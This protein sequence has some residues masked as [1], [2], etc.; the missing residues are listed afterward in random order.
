MSCRAL[1]LH[2]HYRVFFPGT[3]SILSYR[4]PC[5]AILYHFLAN[6]KT[7]LRS[8]VLCFVSSR[9]CYAITVDSLFAY[10]EKV[11]V[12]YLAI[13]LSIHCQNLEV[14]SLEEDG[15]NYVVI[16]CCHRPGYFVQQEDIGE[17]SCHPRPKLDEV[18]VYRLL[19]LI[20]LGDVGDT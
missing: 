15:G 11:S 13:V 6:M 7:A 4:H 10:T 16:L 20:M 3:W 12:S 1:L 9:S 14:S 2:H 8:H 19:L 17:W 18:G 5:I